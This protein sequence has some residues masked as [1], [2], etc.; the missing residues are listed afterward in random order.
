MLCG[1]WAGGFVLMGLCTLCRVVQ[2]RSHFTRHA[3][4]VQQTTRPS[5]RA[6]NQQSVRSVFDS[7]SEPLLLLASFTVLHLLTCVTVA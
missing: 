5:E 7:L 6:K 3:Q 2:C 1:T 4:R